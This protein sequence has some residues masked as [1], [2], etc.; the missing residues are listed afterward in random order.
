[1]STPSDPPAIIQN[2]LSTATQESE[3]GIIGLVKS[4]GDGNPYFSAGF[5]LMGV[6]VG[7]TALRRSVT[8]LTTLAQ[9]RLL[10]SLEIPIRDHSHAWFLEWMAHQSKNRAAH[11][12]GVR[13]H[14]HQL[15]V[16]TTKTTHSNG[17][18]DV[19]FSLV[20]APGT[21]WFRYRG[22]WI[23]VKREREGK[24]LD[25]NSGV[26]WETVTLTTLAR[27]RALFS[28][29]LSE[30]RD[31]ALRGNEGRTVV[32]IARGIEWTQFGRPRRKREIGSVVLA[33][34]V[35]DRILSDVRAFMERGKWYAERGI[36]YRRGYL[37]HGPPGSGKSSFIQALAGSLGYNICVLNL[38][39]RGLT[40]DKLNYLLAH[41]PER[42]FVLLEDIDAAFNKR[43]QTSDDGYQSGVTFS[44]LLNALDGVASGEE[45]IVFMTT[46]HLSRLDPA[47]VR[48]GRVDLIQLLDDA[49]P[50]QA[51]Q[52][53]ARFYRKESDEQKEKDLDLD[54]LTKKVKSIAEDEVAQGRRASMAA[55]QG[56]FILYGADRAVK[57]L[58][59]CFSVP[60][61]KQ[62]N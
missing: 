48:P 1:M 2:D 57:T 11:S 62:V 50:D 54:E 39:E 42:S 7:L 51:A 24:L 17:A 8:L 20:P 36:P 15:A 56:H 38:S 30:A 47:L 14:S 21:H 53:F 49:Q 37:L 46:N 61:T 60:K 34:G 29:L 35:A 19:L 10:V 43:V 55:L 45:R 28:T 6:G 12:G 5:G 31:L 18:S 3:G 22:A 33:E 26:P 4:L 40:D 16:E 41:V 13:I 44:G 52:L 25:L 23:Q 59:D 32:Y 9:R 58:R 27:D